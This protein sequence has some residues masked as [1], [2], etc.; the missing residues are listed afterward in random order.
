MPEIVVYNWEDNEIINYRLI[1][2]K[3]AI[4][5]HG[6]INVSAFG[7]I[8]CSMN[9]TI[10]EWQVHKGM[11]KCL[12]SLSP[13]TNNINLVFENA[14][15]ILTI[16][17]KHHTTELCIIP[18][19]LVCDGH[20][21]RFQSPIGCD[22]SIEN[23]CLRIGLGVQLIQ[24]IFAE[25]LKE[26]GFSKKSFQIENDLNSTAPLC[27]IF[28]SKLSLTD[29]RSW[30]QIKLWEYFGRELMLSELGNENRKF[31]AFLSCTMW[32][33]NRVIGDPALA[34]GGLALVG[35]GCLH[36][37]PTS[38]EQV[39]S[40]FTNDTKIDPNL[41][42]NSYYRGTYGGCYSTT[43]GSV[44]HEVGHMF[45]L[46]HTETGIMSRGFDYTNLV[47]TTGQSCPSKNNREENVDLLPMLE[48]HPSNPTEVILVKPL[49]KSKYTEDDLTHLTHACA[50]ILAHHKWFNNDNKSPSSIYYDKIRSIITSEAGLKVVQI[51]GVCGAVLK[52][53]ELG[54]KA[55]CKHLVLPRTFQNK[56]VTLIAIDTNGIILTQKI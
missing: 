36:T 37:W 10:S 50:S 51:R 34:G 23:A 19:Y 44:C 16:V 9:N 13:G 41:L 14:N 20:N 11:F 18:V 43:L 29:A 32:D 25:K 26:N 24:C 35:T 38:L 49:I 22:N 40:C 31:L 12:T 3:G 2:I 27:Q 48:V 4:T 56:T 8:T 46:G 45:N 39:I 6:I 42:D 30:D 7:K 21:G 15:K 53:W 55:L 5:E 33:G 17:L 28:H 47:F 54:T 52:S 1:V